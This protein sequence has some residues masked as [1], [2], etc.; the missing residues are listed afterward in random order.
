MRSPLEYLMGPGVVMKRLGLAI[1]VALSMMIVSSQAANRWWDG[2]NTG[3]TGDG[4]SDGGTETW[5]T[6]IQ[7]WDQGNGLARVSWTNANNDT[8]IFAG[9]AGTVALGTGITIGG[10]QFDTAS[11]II[12]SNTLT[13]GTAG[14]IVV[15]EDATIGAI[16]A[17]SVAIA[18]SGSGALTLTAKSTSTGGLTVD[19]GTLILKATGNAGTI[20]G[21]LTVNSGATVT[22]TVANSMG[23]LTTVNPLNING[24]NVDLSAG[25]H[26]FLG[27]TVNMVGGTLKFSSSTFN[28]H[29]NAVYNVSNS[30]SQ[31]QILVQPGGAMRMIS[32]AITPC[33]TFNV[34]DGSQDVDLLVEA[35]ITVGSGAGG[36]TKAGAGTAKFT[37]TNT[38]TGGTIVSGGTLVLDKTGKNGTTPILP[39]N[40]NLT[41]TNAT[42]SLAGGNTANAIYN[43]SGGT[44]TL[45]GGGTLAASQTTFNAHSLY[46]VVMAGGL[47][48]AGAGTLDGTFANWYI[49]NTISSTADSTISA[50]LGRNS[51]N[52]S[53]PVN[54]ANGTTLLISGPLVNIIGANG[55]TKSGEGTL[56]L[57]GTNTYTGV[58]TVN[59]G[60]LEISGAGLL[61]SGS[62]AAGIVNNGVLLLN[63]TAEQTLGGIISGT[64][65]LVK[66]S[67]V[68]LTLT[69]VSS[70][71]GGTTVNAGT[72]I[73]GAGGNN[74][75]VRGALT[76]NADATVTATVANAFGIVNTLSTLNINGGNVDLATGQQHIWGT[77]VN[78]VGGTLK[79]SSNTQNEQFNVVYNVSNSTSQAQILAQPGGAMRM[80]SSTNTPCIAFNV[81]DGSQDVDLLVDV[82]ITNGDGAGGVTK[83]GAGTVE[84]TKANT[85]PG[86]TVIN[87]GALI[88]N[89]SHS[90]GGL[91]YTVTAA[92]V[93]S[94]TGTISSAVTVDGVIAPG[95]GGIG[96]LTVG[97]VKWAAGPAW[98]FELGAASSSDRL[99]INGGFTNSG[100]TGFAFDLQNTGV[101]G[102]YTLVTWTASTTFTNTDFAANNVPAELTPAFTMN[103]NSLMLELT[104]SGGEE[105][106]AEATNTA[107]AVVS[108]QVVFGFNIA[109]GALYHVQAST[110]LQ[111]PVDNGFTNI[112]SQLTNQ[113]AGTM[114]YTNTTSDPLRMFRI[115]SP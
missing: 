107:I 3:G 114:I 52:A 73:L 63:S 5:N 90:G 17:G 34:E 43:T 2:A 20:R 104:S 28:E 31:A 106:T 33:I 30:T 46:N 84:I 74:A 67:S 8:A 68:T 93:L 41:I 61:G 48:T 29:S 18:K 89:G 65:A 36:L 97:S 109:S 105:I 78:M 115:T 56:R 71:T 113:Q 83:N 92:G 91:S 39:A 12:Q 75:C 62:Y 27:V 80:R 44:I 76:V 7:N 1:I 66:A 55:L 72:L 95:S 86:P 54:V 45:S 26:Q 50:S 112:T 94:G 64:G 35:P 6:S 38:Y 53:L 24:G 23:I 88:M 47:L 101:V 16:M 79:F 51:N 82:P 77:T 21:A 9:T 14:N 81:E 57:S 99:A 4:A 98:P 42:V 103:A 25:Q 110:N 85:Y 59:A 22:S 102:V 69:N 108:G 37:G 11:Y 40:N 15:N 10:L 49:N 96:T 111:A 19:A 58:S 32:S 100:G 60:T 87:G 70:Y 13:W